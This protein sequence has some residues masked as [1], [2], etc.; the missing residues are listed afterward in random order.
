MIFMQINSTKNESFVTI[1]LKMV[2]TNCNMNCEYCYEHVSRNVHRKFSKSE[3]IIEYLV[4]FT[5][6]DHV[7]IV[8]HGGEPL[9]AN[10]EEV[11]AILN[12][13]KEHFKKEY[14]IQFQ[15]NGTLLDDEWIAIFKQYEPNLSL[16]VSLDPE[17]EKDLRRMNQVDYRKI[18]ENNLKKYCHEIQN[19]GVI[20]V[21]HKSNYRSFQDFINELIGMGVRSLTINKYRTE[22]LKDENYLAEKEYVEML[23]E[24]FKA[25]VFNGWYRVINIQ[26]LSSLFSSQGSRI[27]IYLPDENKCSYFK[28]YYAE[29]EKS[30]YCDHITCGKSPRLEPRCLSCEIYLKCG[31]GCLAET[32]N[33]IFCNAR[34]E[35][36][37]FIEEV[38]HEGKQTDCQ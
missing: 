22:N 20:A 7:F 34:K 32:K 5:A 33:D 21:A 6:Y 29:T 17:G 14:R 26:P 24:I 36:F 25:W 30:D 13:I 27:C 18:V 8:F 9:L 12:F 23:K 19:V 4:S 28:T 11:R 16:S 38:K 2:G 10:R 35:L 1:M 31:G 15:T 3:Q 37:S